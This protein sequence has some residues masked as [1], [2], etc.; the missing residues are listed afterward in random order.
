[1]GKAILITG[2]IVAFVALL[3]LVLY[4]G[5]SIEPPRETTPLHD[6]AAG[7]HLE[8][9][10]ELAA[11]VAQIDALDESG[12]TPLHLAAANG[13][14]QT[15]RTLLELGADPD[16][17]DDE[18]LSAYDHAVRNGHDQTGSALKEAGGKTAAAATASTEHRLNPSLKFSDAETFSKAIGEGA[19]VLES[20]HVYFFVPARLE[21]EAGI[22]FPYLTAAYDALYA[23]VG[24]HTEYAM[25][26]FAFPYGHGEAFGGTSNCVIYYDE[27]NLHLTEHDEWNKH[28]V[29]HVS[30]YIEEMA[31][32]FVAATGA[33]FGW[34]ML[35]WSVGVNATDEVASNPIH[36]AQV[37]RTR[38]LQADTYR[39]YVA[40]GFVLPADVPANKVD[41]IHA[42]IL[43]ELE[44][45]YGPEFWPVFFEQIRLRRERLA[46]ANRL[47]GD[48]GRNSRYR[49]TI[50]AFDALPGVD[51][52][53]KLGAAGISRVVDVKSL[54][55][56]S[57]DWDRRLQ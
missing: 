17:V 10:R 33:Q 5:R 36:S 35:G 3:P 23:I 6:A 19:V 39:R 55:P 50:E 30:G 29:P 51:M 12:C 11:G 40:S 21:R 56:T 53:A 49:T 43:F 13:H 34:E 26:V 31:H 1:M 18:G 16:V 54:D 8:T 27:G 57:P 44:Q 37:A 42:W 22:V 20:E 24:Q 7:G 38:E 47:G 48:D 41:R 52:S 45:A 4:V 46:N 9:V 2:A 25:A 15:V 28:R 32:N 14:L